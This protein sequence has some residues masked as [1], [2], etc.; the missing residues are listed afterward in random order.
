V[1]VPHRLLT[2]HG[3]PQRFTTQT[4]G[5]RNAREPRRRTS[6]CSGSGAE[7]SAYWCNITL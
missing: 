7:T 6:H 4:F 5:L 1:T 2:L 3:L